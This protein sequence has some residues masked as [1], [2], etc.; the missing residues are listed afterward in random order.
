MA[1]PL[2]GALASLFLPHV[3]GVG[4]LRAALLVLA[5]ISLT[6]ALSAAIWMRDAPPPPPTVVL[7]AAPIPTRDRRIWRLGAG[8]ALLVVSQS[9]LV[10]FVV[11]FLHDAR[12][13]APATAAAGLA[14]IQLGGAVTRIVAGRSS[15]REG[16]RIAPIRR[17]A[18]AGAVLLATT[19]ALV[20]APG[21]VLYPVLLAAGITAMTWNG[22]AFTAAAEISGRKRAGTAMSVQNTLIAV[23]TALAPALFGA[24]VDASS[25]SVAYGLCALAPLAAYVVLG[26]LVDDEE[27]RVRERVRRRQSLPATL[28]P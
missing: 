5:G 22:L 19:A 28:S 14:A 11:L 9:S 20:D 23:G 8:S 24:V 21:A 16:M 13:L 3:V 17:I 10:G 1:L 27:D 4:G 18:I 2:G 15:D 26:P 25:W 7:P 6:A 12:G